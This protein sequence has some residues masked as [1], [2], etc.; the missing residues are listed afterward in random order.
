M[1]PAAQTSMTIW[2]AWFC[3]LCVLGGAGL[4]SLS[5]S[6]TGGRSRTNRRFAHI[7]RGNA[8]E[9]ELRGR[10]QQWA[11]D[12]ADPAGASA[13]QQEDLRLLA[14]AGW[15]SREAY[16]FF[17]CARILLP[18]VSAVGV[19]GFTALYAPEMSAL[20][21]GLRALI[22]GVSGLLAP[23]MALRAMASARRRRIDEE[24]GPLA[25]ILCVLFE[26][27]L[28]LE[29]SLR[30][31]VRE[32]GAILHD[33][34]VEI[35]LLLRQIASGADRSEALGAM[36]ADLGVAD[37]TD[38]TRLLA[39]IERHGGAAREALRR[40]CALHADR[41]RTALQET[42]SK[43]SAKMTVVMVL[44]LFPALLVFIGG[45]G[46]ISIKRALEGA[47]G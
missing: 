14:C 34:R 21:S 29:Q 2:V 19:L 30:V 13:E 27:G 36:A 3:A 8:L 23:R 17:A 33:L 43:L 28:S 5:F 26:S 18:A 42:V 35:E 4:L 47:G 25:Q 9:L 46:F 38:L 7:V 40:F 32:G 6:R 41:R 12:L 16:A 31:L 1:G 22:A 37:L 15:R 10:L 45:P 20:H 24:V 39:Q 11:R 44:C